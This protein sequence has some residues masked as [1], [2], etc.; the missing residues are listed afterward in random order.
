[1]PA[2]SYSTGWYPGNGFCILSLIDVLQLSKLSECFN[3]SHRTNDI[4]TTCRSAKLVRGMRQAPE[5]TH[6]AE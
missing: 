2:S 6:E 3:S 4:L 5:S 1:L